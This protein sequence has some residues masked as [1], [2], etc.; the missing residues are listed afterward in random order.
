VDEIEGQAVGPA[1]GTLQSEMS[2]IRE[3]VLLVASGGSSRVTVA[4]LRFGEALLAPARILAAEHGVRIQPQWW[5]DDEGASVAVE[6][7]ALPG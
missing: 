6:R 7:A 4:G 2:L 3:A 5:P 1:I